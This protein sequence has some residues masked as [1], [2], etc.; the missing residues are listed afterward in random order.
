MWS[1]DSGSSRTNS[2]SRTKGSGMAT[3]TGTLPGRDDE[4]ALPN[5][6]KSSERPDERDDGPDDGEVVQRGRK[7]DVIGVQ[8][9]GPP[10]RQRDLCRSL[11]HLPGR[12]GGHKLRTTSMQHRLADG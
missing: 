12:L 6:E 5:E 9:F 2:P 11:P 3:T 7:G 10:G 8:Q 4:V 1:S